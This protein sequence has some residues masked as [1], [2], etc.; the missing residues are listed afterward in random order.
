MRHGEV[1]VRALSERCASSTAV[2]AVSCAAGVTEEREVEGGGGGGG[3]EAP[4]SSSELLR[5]AR[6]ATLTDSLADV[7]GQE[8]PR[9]RM[10]ADDT[11]ICRGSRSGGRG[12]QRPWEGQEPR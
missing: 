4:S 3:G 11:V 6:D 7:F 10:S 2:T 8:A 12:L 5:P 1:A 9:A